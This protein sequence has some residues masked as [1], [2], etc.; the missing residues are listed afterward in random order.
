MS[1]LNENILSK[2]LEKIWVI[3]VHRSGTWGFVEITDHKIGRIVYLDLLEDVLKTYKQIVLCQ[4]VD[5]KQWRIGDRKQFF[6]KI[7]QSTSAT[8][9]T[10]SDFDSITPSKDNDEVFVINVSTTFHRGL[11][12]QVFGTGGF[13]LPNISFAFNEWTENWN[14]ETGRLNKVVYSWFHLK[15]SDSELIKLLEQVELICLTIDGHLWFCLKDEKDINRLLLSV[16]KLAT[17]RSIKVV[18]EPMK[19]PIGKSE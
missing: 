8:I 15:S 3:R 14:E 13:N 6:A 9:T 5:T 2:F 4:K 12:E 1:W 7:Q 10:T 11:W 19:I 16:D 17:A 18:T